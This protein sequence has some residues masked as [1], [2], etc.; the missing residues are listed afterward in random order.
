MGASGQIC[1][2]SFSLSR[3]FPRSQPVRTD[4][5]GPACRPRDNLATHSSREHMRTSVPKILPRRKRQPLTRSEMMARIRSRDTCPEVQTRAAVHALRLRFRNHVA[6]LPGKPDLANK[7]RRWAIFVHGCFWHSHR[8][9]KLA[10]VPKSNTAYW[11]EKLNRNQVRDAQK[12]AAL[13]A[14]GFRVLIIWECE[15]RDSVRL[16]CALEQFFPRDSAT[17]P[18]QSC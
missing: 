5:G 12:I 16:G 10:S 9:C 15:V 2:Q 11:T 13:R 14:R 18:R 7:K 1:R 3:T 8:E 4:S 17:K 6:N